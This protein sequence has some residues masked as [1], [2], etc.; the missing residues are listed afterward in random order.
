MIKI[1]VKTVMVRKL[2]KRK[3][4][5][6]SLLTREH[7][8]VQNMCYMEKLMNSQELNLVMLLFK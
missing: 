8:M 3:K 7:P 1:N 4:Y 2:P 5:L 6:M